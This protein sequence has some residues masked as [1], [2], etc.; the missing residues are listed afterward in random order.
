MYTVSAPWCQQRTLDPLDCRDGCEL[1]CRMLASPLAVLYSVVWH[2]STTPNSCSY[3]APCLPAI[4]YCCFNVSASH[5]HR[6]V[7]WLKDMLA[8]YPV[9]FCMFRMFCMRCAN[10]K[11]FYKA[12]HSEWP[13]QVK[14]QYELLCLKW[15]ESEP[16]TGQSFLHL[17]MSSLC[18]CGWHWRMLL[19]SQKIKSIILML[20]YLDVLKFPFITLPPLNL[21]Y[22][23]PV[24]LKISW[25][26]FV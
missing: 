5:G 22:S 15:L 23:G 4:L 17:R 13:H 2:L 20:Y 21:W 3:F 9:L 14:G 11:K 1:L 8:T 6:E 16:I 26:Y 25:Q 12:L 7:T 24:S 19:I 18:F 10:L